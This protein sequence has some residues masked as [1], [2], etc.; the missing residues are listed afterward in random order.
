M[1][2]DRL[3]LILSKLPARV[4]AYSTA[5]LHSYF[6]D[7]D[8]STVDKALQRFVQ[9]GVLERVCRGVYVDPSSFVQHPYKLESI[10]AALRG[11][12]Y[13]YVSAES[14]LSEYGVISQV[15]L[16]YLSVMTL[17]RSQRYE[18]PYGTLELVHSSRS[19]AEIFARTVSA[20][21]RP[22]RLA[23][24]SLAFDDLKRLRRNV[25]LIDHDTLAELTLH[26]GER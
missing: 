22:L 24:P 7:E 6:P 8:A 1:V 4:G 25:S 20:V 14:A 11:G 5:M 15:V 12:E 2:Q 3:R 17:G 21:D 19:E 13:S 9:R 16:G 26:E 18:T 10:A 23:S